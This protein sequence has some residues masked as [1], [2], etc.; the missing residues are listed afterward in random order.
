MWKLRQTKETIE[1]QLKKDGHLLIRKSDNVLEEID[2]TITKVVPEQS[3]EAI[4]D[5]IYKHIPQWCT[6][7]GIVE[8]NNYDSTG[9][10]PE[11]YTEVWIDD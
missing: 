1:R 6:L 3:A 8:M 5:G 2:W 9:S 10:H 7:E 11:T 4:K